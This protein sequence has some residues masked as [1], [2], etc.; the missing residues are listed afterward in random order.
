M[1][2]GVTAKVTVGKKRSS[3]IPLIYG[4]G[5]AFVLTPTGMRQRLLAADRQVAASP[6]RGNNPSVGC[7]DSSLYTRETQKTMRRLSADSNVVARHATY[8]QYLRT[9]SSSVRFFFR[10]M[11]AASSPT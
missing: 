10:M 9:N 1:N 7:A 4:D 3:S 5:A 2:F 6:R 8:S 11:A